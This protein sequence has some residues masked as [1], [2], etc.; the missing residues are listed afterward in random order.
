MW[1]K[2]C[3]LERGM[4]Q[5]ELAKKAGVTQRLISDFERNKIVIRIDTLYRILMALG[6][7]HGASEYASWS[8]LYGLHPGR[9]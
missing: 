8:L 5:A 2:S 9:C 7:I 4:T 1:L 3:R 6:L